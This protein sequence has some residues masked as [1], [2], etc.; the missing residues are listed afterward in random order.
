MFTSLTQPSRGIKKRNW[1]AVFLI[2]IKIEAQ[3]AG[4]YT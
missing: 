4:K 2:E 3:V 1:E